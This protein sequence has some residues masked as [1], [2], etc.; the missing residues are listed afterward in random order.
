MSNS[1][2]GSFSK[3]HEAEQSPSLKS[4]MVSYFNKIKT[5]FDIFQD[6]DIE[7]NSGRLFEETHKEKEIKELTDINIFTT[8]LFT[9]YKQGEEDSGVR[10]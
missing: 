7:G 9:E 3:L 4:R 6:N 8:K 2:T 5:N 1:S 10:K